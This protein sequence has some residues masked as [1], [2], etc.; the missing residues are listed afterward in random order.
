MKPFQHSGPA[1]SATHIANYHLCRARCVVENA[2]GRMKARFCIVHEGLEC[3]MGHVNT[4]IRACCVLL[5]IYE[6]VSD[7]CDAGWF[8]VMR[9]E[10]QMWCKP[11]CTSSRCE[12]SGVVV[13]NALENIFLKTVLHATDG[14]VFLFFLNVL[15]EFIAGTLITFMTGYVTATSIIII[16]NTSICIT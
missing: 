4:A 1:E 15:H 2:F 7:R 5:S 10:N 3:G 6:Q 9:C 8:D 12:S 16:S 14:I 11:L 13:R